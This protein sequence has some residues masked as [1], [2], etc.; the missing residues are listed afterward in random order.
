MFKF[1]LTTV[2]SSIGFIVSKAARICLGVEKGDNVYLTPAPGGG[3]RITPHDPD[4]ALDCEAFRE[5]WSEDR[6]IFKE[7]SK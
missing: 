1:T 2:G 6:D 3:F 7:L 5:I 4:F